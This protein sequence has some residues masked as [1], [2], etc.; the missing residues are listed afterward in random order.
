[1]EQIEEAQA[2][3]YDAQTW[4]L[5]NGAPLCIQANQN[6]ASTYLSNHHLALVELLRLRITSHLLAVVQAL[7]YSGTEPASPTTNAGAYG[8]PEQ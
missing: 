2:E 1:L 8:S 6:T 7:L 3:L 4:L 5:E